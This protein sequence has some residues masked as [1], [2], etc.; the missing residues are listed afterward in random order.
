MFENLLGAVS[1]QSSLGFSD[2][3]LVVLNLIIA[4]VLCLLVA[5]T[6]KKT[7]KG[8]SYSQSYVLTLIIGGLVITAVMMVIGNNIARAF[9]AFGAFSLIR[10][11][12][13]IK[14]AKDMGYMFLVLAVGMAIGSNNYVVA[15][16]TT[17]IVLG[18]MLVLNRV[19]FGSI[20]KFDYILSFHLDTR[21]TKENAYKIVFDKYLKANSVL[22]IKAKE[23][24]HILQLSFNIKFLSE[25]DSL[26]FTSDLE[27]LEGVSDVIL[28]TAKNDVE[29]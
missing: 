18:V 28:I 4:F 11:R 1:N 23:Q 20:R 2:P 5:V 26:A 17:I 25:K 8:L 6:Y 29:Y 15:F 12:T 9:G 24:G 7:H 21:E 3:A 27:K 22:N 10:F 13:A 16:A 19:N 14:D